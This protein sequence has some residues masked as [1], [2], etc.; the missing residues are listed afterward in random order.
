MSDT[1]DIRNRITEVRRM[2]LGDVAQCPFNW[3][4]HPLSQI[5]AFEGVLKELG[6]MGVPLAYHS[7]KVGGLAWADGNMR[8]K[9][10]PDLEADVG[11]T[12]LTDEEVKYALLTYDPIAAMAEANRE[13]LGALLQG[14]QSD[15]AAVQE[16]LSELAEREGVVLGG[17]GGGGGVPD[18]PQV[19]KAAELKEKWDTGS[20]QVWELGEHRLVCGDCMDKVVVEAVM[21]NE[22]AQLM[23][24]DPPYNVGIKYADIQDEKAEKEYESFCL[25]WFRLWQSSSEKQIVTPGYYNLASWCRFFEK[26]YHIAPWTKTNSMTRGHV[27]RF[28]C[29]EPI[30]FYGA[31]WKRE[32]AN[33]VFNFPI[34]EQRTDSGETLTD[35][36]PCPKPLA[37]W[38]DLIN[39]YTDIGDIVADPFGGSGTCIIA[40]EHFDRK[41][42]AVEISPAYVAVTLQRWH[43]LTGLD[44]QRID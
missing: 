23:V 7:E 38:E 24:T 10:L 39:N 42:R 1:P 32:R 27:S 34:G 4:D 14:V 43:D 26:P 22:K 20:G 12:D 44:P 3:K 40:C 41:C 6:W 31:K 33:D 17:N 2:R 9:R 35:L 5:K 25:S 15:Q 11:I 19:D 21:G 30:F 18:L 13:K 29:F 16:M 37:M 28:V 36:H 8:G